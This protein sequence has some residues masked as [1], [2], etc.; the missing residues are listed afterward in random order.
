MKNL[1]LR[2]AL[3]RVL[4]A[5]VVVTLAIG[6]GVSASPAEAQRRGREADGASAEFAAGRAAFDAGDWLTALQHFQAAF[7][8]RPHDAVRFNLA[9][10][11]ERLGRPLE[12]VAQYEAAMASTVLDEA[13][14]LQARERR[15]ALLATVAVLLIEGQASEVVVDGARPCAMP[16]RTIV[17]A[18]EH[19]LRYDGAH[20]EQVSV[21]AGERRR[22]AFVV[23][24][25]H[26]ASSTPAAVS[27]PPPTAPHSAPLDA[28]H[29]DTAGGDELPFLGSPIF[30][31]GAGLTVVGAVSTILFAVLTEDAHARFVAGGS[32]DLNL[33]SEGNLY[34]DLT[35]VSWIA[36][37]VGVVVAVVDVLFIDPPRSRST[38]RGRRAA[39][40]AL[41]RF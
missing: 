18:G 7:E 10:C 41:F 31:G 5:L 38:A 8:I 3:V 29:E 16:C 2:F 12:A 22:I 30:W 25:A 1:R 28:E 21:M 36:A 32:S 15:D 37:A 4:A 19:T 27:S 40:P 17:D 26:A 9:V 11:F 23:P 20:T 24:A 6:A 33:A 14:R 39:D 35:N 34:R 13:A